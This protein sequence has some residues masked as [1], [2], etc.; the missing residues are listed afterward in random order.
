MTVEVTST[1]N[2]Y[3]EGC[4]YFHDDFK[5]QP[6]TNRLLEW[7]EFFERQFALGRRFAVF[8]GAEPALEQRRLLAAAAFFRRG[9]VYTN[10]TIRINDE[11]PFIRCVSIWG[12]EESTEKIRG[13]S[14]YYKALR[15]FEN[16]PKARFSV[17]VNAQNWQELP[18]I[19]AD[20]HA[21]GVSA[22]I[23]YFSPSHSYMAKL[24]AS[25]PNDSAFFRFSGEDDHMLMSTASFAAV[26]S[27]ICELGDRYP[28][29]VRQGPQFN[30]WL[31]GE[32]PRYTLDEDGLAN[33]CAVRPRDLHQ[34]YGTDLRPIAGKCALPDNDCAECRITPVSATSILHN[35][36]AYS[37]S[38]EALCFWIEAAFQAGQVFIR[39][40]DHEV[41]GEPGPPPMNRWREHYRAGVK[42]PQPA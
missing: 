22:T 32:G 6:E 4:F 28:G 36:K 38:L 3:C 21:A 1:C 39:D 30:R 25:A 13:A 15:N 16:D 17:V 24:R 19:V 35:V 7:N 18:R 10:G 33:E 42:A 37:G 20:L 23:S 5:P 11:I 41:W 31:T 9:I 14:V 27:M 29:T 40:D 12:S 34:L 8:H 26:N 2:L